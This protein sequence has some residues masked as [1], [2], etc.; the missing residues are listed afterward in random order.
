MGLSADYR[1]CRALV[2][3]E[4]R[5]RYIS[6]LFAPAAKRKYLFALYA[7]NAEIARVAEQVRE[8]MM[9]ELRLQWWRD[10]VDGHAAGDA[11]RNPVAHALIDTIKTC[12][13]SRAYFHE[14]LDARAFDFYSEP[15]ESLSRLET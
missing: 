9:G 5:D 10:A 8:P 6:V 7:F 4:D 15:M 11:S 2:R 1:A 3:A 13:L 12:N 14:L